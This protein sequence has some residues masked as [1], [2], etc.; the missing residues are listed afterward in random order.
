MRVT[1]LRFPWLVVL[2]LCD[3]ERSLPTHGHIELWP[4][5]FP[6]LSDVSAVDCTAP[7]LPRFQIFA[8]ED[9]WTLCCRIFAMHFAR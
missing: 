6:R 4:R 3:S 7:D 9:P 2:T 1:T 5:G 8:Q